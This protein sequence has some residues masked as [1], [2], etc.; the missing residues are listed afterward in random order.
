M[1]I[2]DSS[3]SLPCQSL[4]PRPRSP[5]HSQTNI[6]S[7]S[8]HPFLSILSSWASQTLLLEFYS[9]SDCHAASFIVA[10]KRHGVVF[11]LLPSGRHAYETTAVTCNM[12]YVQNH[13]LFNFQELDIL[14]FLFVSFHLSLL[15]RL[16]GCIFTFYISNAQDGSSI[17]VPRHHLVHYRI[18][19]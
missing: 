4:P 12:H 1:T 13:P 6:T 17:A 3:L 15:D 9:C 5:L 8:F 7:L 19:K 14:F 18:W 11:S 2:R 10:A 16:F